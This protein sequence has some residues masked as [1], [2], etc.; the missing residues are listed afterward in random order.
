MVGIMSNGQSGNSHPLL[1]VLTVLVCLN[2]AVTAWLAFI[3]FEEKEVQSAG[4][5]EL[6]A[7]LDKDER[8]RLFQ[9]IQARYNAE[10]FDAL[11]GMMDE[12]AQIELDQEDVTQILKSVKVSFGDIQRGVFTHY[13]YTGERQ[14]RFWFDLFYSVRFGGGSY[15]FEKGVV[16]ISVFDDGNRYGFTGV[17]FADK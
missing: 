1:Y 10:D 6:P 5:K 14:G 17:N 2:L 4:E 12:S 13:V 9:S 15:G 7:V 3:N 11:Y 8:D 16:K